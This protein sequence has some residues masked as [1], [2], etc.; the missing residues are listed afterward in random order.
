MLPLVCI[1]VDGTLIGSSGVPSERVLETINS[2]LSRGQ[3][4]CL[5]TARGAMGPTFRYAEM[6]NPNGWHIFHSGGALLHTGSDEVVEHALPQGIVDLAL[7]VSQENNWALEFYS[8]R[9]YRSGH[10]AGSAAILD[11][12]G[13]YELAVAH[14]EMLGVE[15]VPGTPSDLSGGIVRVQFVVGESS[16]NKVQEAMSGFGKL[17]AATSPALPG[18]AFISVTDEGVDKGSAISYLALKL[19]FDLSDVMMVGDGLNDLDALNVVGHPV[20]MG[21]AHTEVLSVGK[22]IVSSVEEDGLCEA[23]ELSWD[24]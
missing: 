7:E 14:S 4:L 11:H 24:L 23:I 12:T 1:D 13:E 15:H 16:A 5:S 3:Q 22:Y 18:A 6:L 10:L 21:N 19:G 17:T 8:A 2:A 20:A 9:D